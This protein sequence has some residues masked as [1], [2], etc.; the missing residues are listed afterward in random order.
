MEQARQL[1]ANGRRGW[2]L[3]FL[4]LGVLV[5]A[6]SAVALLALLLAWPETFD[7]GAST[8]TKRRLVGTWAGANG[9]TIQLRADG[10][11]RSRSA[12]TQ[13]EISY[14]EWSASEDE[15]IVFMGRRETRTRRTI[16]RLVTGGGTADR[17]EIVGLTADQL[18]VR[19]K[20][21]GHR[22]LFTRTS[23]PVLDDA[24]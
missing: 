20:A 16:Q 9:V 15:F 19:D 22:L 10:T 14:F 23:D 6:I 13:P 11:A 18:E 4:A 1:R 24:P 7:S 8:A 2:L 12:K 5:V 3:V 21:S 17:Y